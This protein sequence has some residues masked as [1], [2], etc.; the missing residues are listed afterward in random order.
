MLML[1]DFL[2]AS[3]LLLFVFYRRGKMH[4]T[5]P[6]HM[7]FTGNLSHKF[8]NILF[9]TGGFNHCWYCNPLANA[10]GKGKFRPPKL[11]N[12]YFKP[13]STTPESRNVHLQTVS[14][15]P[16]QNLISIRPRGWSRRIPSLPHW[17]FFLLFFSFVL[18]RVHRSHNTALHDDVGHVALGL[19]C[20]ATQIPFSGLISP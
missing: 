13:I 14:T 17:G 16:V 7:L 20:Y 8:E 11:V 15:Y 2:T 9:F 19:R 3:C 18:C 5:C 12:H 6:M 10:M 1:G 4:R